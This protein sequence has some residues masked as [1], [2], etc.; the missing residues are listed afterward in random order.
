[1]KTMLKIGVIGALAALLALAGCGGSQ[2]TGGSTTPAGGEGQATADGGQ[3]A[4][5]GDAGP[6]EPANLGAALIADRCT[7]CHGMELI[8]EE[9]ND[10]QQWTAVVDDM[11]ERGARLDQAE[12]DAVI[13]YLASR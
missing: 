1:M 7:T 13:E 4:E 3:S 10:S 2:D 6:V 11:I 5:A 9:H 8:D 12:R